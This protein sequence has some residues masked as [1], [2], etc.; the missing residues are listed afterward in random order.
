MKK[1]V[2]LIITIAMLFVTS[3]CKSE[4]DLTAYVSQLRE[5]VYAC[6]VDGVKIS[7]YSERRE[8]PFIADSYVGKLKNILIVKIDAPTIVDDAKISIS[9]DDI[10]A[11]GT[12]DYNPIGAKYTTVIEVE[13][14]PTKQEF[15]G[16]FMVGE[17]QTEV[18]FK[19]TVASGSISSKDAINS[20]KKYD[21]KTIN[22]LFNSDR[23]E[24]EIHIRIMPGGERNYYYVGLVT[25][26]GNTTAYLVD[27]T[28]GE[29]LAK[30]TC[31][32]YN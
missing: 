16:V 6:E 28:S 2:Y 30:K 15:N 25:K 27:G 24:A 4:V 11:N 7:V 1:I 32:T 31:K 22:N 21:S 12:F 26:D 20:V 3:S 8:S 17:K 18:L 23:V 9:Y 13:K 29:V 5:N 14:L 10:S 19:S